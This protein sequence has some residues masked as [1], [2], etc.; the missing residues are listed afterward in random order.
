MACIDED[1]LKDLISSQTLDWC[2]CETMGSLGAPSPGDDMCLGLMPAIG[3][4]CH[5]DDSIQCAYITPYVCQKDGETPL[6][7]EGMND[8]DWERIYD[9]FL[10]RYAERYRHI[11]GPYTK[12]RK[13]RLMR[14]S[15]ER[16]KDM[17]FTCRD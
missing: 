1:R 4:D 5:S 3:F 13:Q 15:R 6:R 8:R 12:A 9:A 14:E 2:G 16:G 7:K 17:V 10:A 11:D